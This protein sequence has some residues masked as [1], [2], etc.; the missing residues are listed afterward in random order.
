MAK[1][2][3]THRAAQTD[4]EDV[5]STLK[6]A[7]FGAPFELILRYSAIV[8]LG[9]IVAITADLPV[10]W[11]WLLC[12][13]ITEG[14]YF[15]QLRQALHHP[16][17]SN[18]RLALLGYMV[19]ATTFVA[20]PMV[21]THLDNPT[22]LA[23][24]VAAQVGMVFYTFWRPRISQPIAIYDILM[25]FGLAVNAA[26]AFWDITTDPW[27]HFVFTS[28]LLVAAVYYAMTIH[29]NL[30]LYNEWEERRLRAAETMKAEALGRLVGGVAHDFNNILTV[31]IG[32]L[33]LHKEVP[34]G[35]E[36]DVL[37]EEAH[38]A[39]L[40][41]ARLTGQL[42]A[43]GRK[44]PL[45]PTVASLQAHVDAVEP[46]LRR[47]LPASVALDIRIPASIQHVALDRAQFTAALLNLVSNAADALGTRRGKIWIK[48]WPVREDSQQKEFA[49]SVI[50]TAGGLP[51]E[52][53]AD[54]LEPYF[55]TKP[56]GSGSGLGLPMVNGFAE[57][58]GGRLILQNRPGE[59]LAVT[60]ILPMLSEQDVTA[61]KPQDGH[62]L[63]STTS[64]MHGARGGP[65]DLRA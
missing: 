62:N 49:L 5:I 60:L 32:N 30:S 25:V 23:A 47:L 55:T 65:S 39:A 41:A 9:S 58:S 10:T 56:I 57:Q 64:P 21:C 2:G 17:T 50:D 33:E 28:V 20:F 24:A 34:P 6:K 22:L 18:M 3:I 13:A 26:I 35:P 46:L 63:A 59:G 15:L 38:E 36:R 52:I 40:R 14:M 48:A 11:L 1:S 42:L 44:A 51:P 61:L 29:R 37:L 16:S 7:D 53:E 45:T 19:T 31:V 12:Y 4:P 54:V 43:Y 8:I 27:A